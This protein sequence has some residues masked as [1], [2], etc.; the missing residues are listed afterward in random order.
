MDLHGKSRSSTVGGVFVPAACSGLNVE[1]VEEGISRKLEEAIDGLKGV[2]RYT[3]VS[4]GG[5]GRAA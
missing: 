1:K 4:S 5:V 3:W 2:E